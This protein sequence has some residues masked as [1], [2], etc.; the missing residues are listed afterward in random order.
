MRFLHPATPPRPR[1]LQ[2]LATRTDRRA[3]GA[4]N[5]LGDHRL[6]VQATASVVQTAGALVGTARVAVPTTNKKTTIG[7]MAYAAIRQLA[8]TADG[9]FQ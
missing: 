7:Q 6:P 8:L 5:F 9:V 1:S 3:R 4:G 2:A